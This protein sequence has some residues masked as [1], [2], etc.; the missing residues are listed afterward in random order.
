VKKKKVVKKNIQNTQNGMVI[1]QAK[2]GAIEL[3]GDFERKTVW[4]TQADIARVF[5]VTIPTINEHLANIF[6]TQELSKDSVIR[7]FRITDL[8]TMCK[9]CTY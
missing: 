1:Y 4:A 6:K 5:G 7:K 2:N 8:K 3:R 9:I